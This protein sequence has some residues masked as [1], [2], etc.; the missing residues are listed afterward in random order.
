MSEPSSERCIGFAPKTER[1]AADV[2]RRSAVDVERARRRIENTEA[3]DAARSKD[4]RRTGVAAARDASH[5]DAATLARDGLKFGVTAEERNR[6]VQETARAEEQSLRP[7]GAA[8]YVS[9][10]VQCAGLKEA[11]GEKAFGRSCHL[12]VGELASEPELTSSTRANARVD[13]AEADGR[14]VTRTVHVVIEGDVRERDDAVREAA[15]WRC[16]NAAS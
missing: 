2:S 11:V 13:L 7:D 4:G 5:D 3:V 15:S 6:G 16:N 12:H 14:E 9:R 1:G 10:E 8:E